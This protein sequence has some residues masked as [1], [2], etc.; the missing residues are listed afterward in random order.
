[1]CAKSNQPESLLIRKR[2]LPPRSD[3]GA[4]DTTVLERSLGYSLRRA[5]LSTYTEFNESMEKFAIR[6]S[7]FALLV[8]LRSNP[9]VT[10]S[11]VAETL[12]IQKAN[13][14]GLLDELQ[15]RGIL[16]R[17]SVPGDRRVF[18][19]Y[20]TRT[21]ESLMKKVEASHAEME[22][23]L[24]RRLDENRIEMLLSLLHAFAGPEQQV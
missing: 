2:K 14:V 9:G 19:L 1:V 10:Q 12:A 17:R 20:L 15:T 16:I 4:L 8:L 7:Q 22:A 18:A 5:Q 21:G 23:K 24:R 3:N 13:L 11:Q 6:P